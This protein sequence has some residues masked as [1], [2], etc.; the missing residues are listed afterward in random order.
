MVEARLRVFCPS[1]AT[2]RGDPSSGESGG[3]GLLGPRMRRSAAYLHSR[4]RSWH[5]WH[6]GWSPEHCVKTAP[7]VGQ[8]MN[9]TE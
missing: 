2:G 1:V 7:V 6:I 4:P 8:N 5:R 9:E 3:F